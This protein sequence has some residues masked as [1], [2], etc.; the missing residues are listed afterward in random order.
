MNSTATIYYTDAGCATNPIRIAY[1][2][3]VPCTVPSTSCSPNTQNPNW[4]T[5]KDC[6]NGDTHAIGS[7]YLGSDLQ[8]YYQST[9]NAQ[10]S[11]CSSA[12]QGGLQIRVNECVPVVEPNAAIQTA[13]PTFQKVY[14]TSPFNASVVVGLYNNATCSQSSEISN[15]LLGPEFSITRG[16]PQAVGKTECY[17]Y[18]VVN[19]RAAWLYTSSVGCPPNTQPPMVIAQKSSFLCRQRSCFVSGPFGRAFEQ[20]CTFRELDGLFFNYAFTNDPYVSLYVN[21]CSG[22][23]DERKMIL[24]YA[25]Q[26][27]PM[28]GGKFLFANVT[29]GA[30][31]VI[32]SEYSEP[33]TSATLT[34][35]EE[36]VISKSASNVTCVAGQPNPL[37]AVVYQPT[38]FTYSNNQN[39][40]IGIGVGVAVVV[41]LVAVFW[42]RGNFHKSNSSN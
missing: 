16:Q 14:F 20:Y 26:C 1:D 19:D 27:T 18:E 22:N 36:Y 10:F 17:E 34:K 33:C 15:T 9:G 23:Q 8:L 31:S 39:L 35:K 29:S 3:T 30:S 2:S 28:E 32:V 12:L 38:V 6:F 21:T 42:L 13:T 25:N 4:F 41:I 7:K 37:V 24:L 11:G 5:K 40:Y